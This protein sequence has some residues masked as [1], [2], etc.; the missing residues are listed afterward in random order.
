MSS[1]KLH[2]ED[3]SREIFILSEIKES[4]MKADEILEK[5]RAERESIVHKARLDA[6]KLISEKANE[7]KKLQEKK[8]MEFRDKVKLLNEEKIAEGKMLAK[9][10]KAKAEKNS[11]KAIELVL[12]KFEEMI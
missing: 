11:L 1:H 10:F 6:A 3:S 2:E 12:K 9:Q 7:V 8:N 4:E 5:A